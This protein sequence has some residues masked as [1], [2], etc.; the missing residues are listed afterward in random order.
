[1]GNGPKIRK[2]LHMGVQF[3]KESDCQRE[4]CIHEHVDVYVCRAR[5]IAAVSDAFKFAEGTIGGPVGVMARLDS[6]KR[7][8]KAVAR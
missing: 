2:S 8:V 5:R 7:A 3:R 6:I 4:R 1:M